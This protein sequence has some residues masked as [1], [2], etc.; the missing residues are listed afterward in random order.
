MWNLRMADAD[1]SAIPTEASAVP[2][3]WIRA[4]LSLSKLYQ[5]EAVPI[6]VIPRAS[7]TADTASSGS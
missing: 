3:P 7:D 5:S 1:V 4:N 6:P 2:P